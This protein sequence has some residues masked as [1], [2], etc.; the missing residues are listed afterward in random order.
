MKLLN[1]LLG[2][3]ILI[4]SSNIQAA[5]FNRNN[6]MIYDDVLN[7]T[8][9]ADA[10]LARS[11]ITA[12]INW[13]TANVWASKLEFGGYT[14]WR[15]PSM[16][17]NND[18]VIVSCTSVNDELGCRD[19][20]YRYMF[21]YNEIQMDM[22]GDF[23]N[24][25]TNHYWSE[26]ENPLFPGLAYLTNMSTGFMGTTSKITINRNA[27]AVRDG[28]VAAVPVPASFYLFITGLAGLF[29]WQKNYK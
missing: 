13:E 12:G 27:W 16:D 24:I 23:I 7:I 5:L 25:G 18:G 11:E 9:L 29:G 14:D 6:G 3:I 19:N 4:V 2:I 8:W 26:T 21:R 28:D 17:V 15:L 20:E 10:G 1:V 22:P